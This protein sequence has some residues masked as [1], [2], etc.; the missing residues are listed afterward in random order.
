MSITN[1]NL[2]KV[3]IFLVFAVH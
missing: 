1:T 2:I 3:N